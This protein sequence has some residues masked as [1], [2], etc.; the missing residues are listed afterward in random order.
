MTESFGHTSIA[1][2]VHIHVYVTGSVKGQMTNM[3]VKV[4][5]RRAACKMFNSSID[6][7]DVCE[8]SAKMLSLMGLERSKVM[9]D[10]MCRKISKGEAE[11]LGLSISDDLLQERKYE[12]A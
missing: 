10:Y 11:S 4:M 12:P 2:F 5:S 9:I 3:S 7:L 6:S 1:R 8:T